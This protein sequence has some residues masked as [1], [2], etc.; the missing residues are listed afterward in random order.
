[1]R[2]QQFLPDSQHG[3]AQVVGPH[4]QFRSGFELACD[5]GQHVAAAHNVFF[6]FRR[7]IIGKEDAD[8][9]LSEK[10]LRLADVQPARIFLDETQSGFA[11][12]GQLAFVFQ[13][14]RRLNSGRLTSGVGKAVAP[15][16]F[17]AR[18]IISG[19]N[20]NL[21]TEERGAAENHD[22]EE[23]GKNPLHAEEKAAP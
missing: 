19:R 20:K 4:D 10:I 8:V 13:F 1:M 17:S 5:P 11:R 12:F 7:R 23:K 3:A 22:R 9:H 6:L 16:F 21:V 2:D 14:R 18:M 15:A